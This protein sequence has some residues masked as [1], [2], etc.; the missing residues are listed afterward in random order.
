[1]TLREPQGGQ[2]GYS[3]CE[4]DLLDGGSQEEH[5]WLYLNTYA[6]GIGNAKKADEISRY[7]GIP[8]REIAEAK[9]NLNINHEKRV[10]SHTAHG[11]WIPLGFDEIKKGG[12]QLLGKG[13]AALLQY[14]RYMGIPMEEAV[15]QMMQMEL[16]SDE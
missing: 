9:S 3:Q 11:Y 6:R 7:T 1:M 16:F 15:K 12:Y 10:A 14:S 13:K 5:L 8:P 2:G 4:L